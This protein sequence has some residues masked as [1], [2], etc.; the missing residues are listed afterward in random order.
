M[1]HFPRRRARSDGQP[2][3]AADTERLLARRG[4][5]PEASA[6]QNAIAGVLDSAAGPVSDDELAGEVAA[7]AT[8]VLVTDQ[9]GTHSARFRGRA[10]RGQVIVVG[11]V[12]S[13]VV[14][15]S[16]AAAANAL[17]APIQQ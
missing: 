12:A 1:S 5:H 4:A 2:L 17:P 6:V 15:F 16:G 8:F 11:V 3:T 7:V 9:R 14:A 10:R 13:A